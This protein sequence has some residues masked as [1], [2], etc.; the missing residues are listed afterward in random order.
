M[1]IE[2]FFKI[3]KNRNK[4]LKILLKK[5]EELLEEEFDILRIIK[6]IRKFKKE[7]ESKFIID[8]DEDDSSAS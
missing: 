3:C 5:G 8:L 4:E 6:S 7:E 2:R 1:F